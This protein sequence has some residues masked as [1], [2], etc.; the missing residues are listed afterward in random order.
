[1]T[2][3]SELGTPVDDQ[4]VQMEDV[5]IPTPLTD[6]QKCAR[7][8]GFEKEVNIFSARMD[9]V[10]DMLRIE[11]IED[12]PHKETM[13][14]LASEL[15]NLE[16]KVKFLEGKVTEFLPC[17]AALCKHNYKFR[18]TKNSKRHADPILRPAKLTNLTSKNDNNNKD[19]EFTLPKK[20]VKP[21]PVENSKISVPTT[22][23]FAVLMKGRV[24]A[25]LNW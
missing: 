20:T 24:L 4:S 5:S 9:Y 11:K 3:I 13:E 23:S 18:N 16:R 21:V 7:I 25:P 6:E 12:N 22:N 15:Q 10:Q 19:N 2:S 1:M 14:Q 8:K 17:P